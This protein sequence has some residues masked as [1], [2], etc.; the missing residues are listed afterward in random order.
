LE[1]FFKNDELSMF[2]NKI[3]DGY[4]ENETDE[5]RKD[6]STDLEEFETLYEIFNLNLISRRLF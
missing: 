4:S 5:D 3:Y 6:Y 1:D 2:L